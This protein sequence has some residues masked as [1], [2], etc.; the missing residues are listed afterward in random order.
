[1][2][3]SLGLSFL[4]LI[5]GTQVIGYSAGDK[6]GTCLCFKSPIDLERLRLPSTL[7]SETVEP[8]LY[9]LSFSPLLSGLWSS[10]KFSAYPSPLQMTALESPA[11]AQYMVS[12]SISTTL[13]VHP[14]A[15]SERSSAPASP[16][17]SP[18]LRI[19]IKG[20]WRVFEDLLI[21]VI[22]LLPSALPSSQSI[23]IKHLINAFS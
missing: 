7:P 19:C 23:S 18:P 8:A 11:F 22:S 10:D 6:P 12:L 21:S 16:V 9:I 20:D 2:N 1:M 5:S 3:S 13:A 15:S 14:L 4:V 17:W